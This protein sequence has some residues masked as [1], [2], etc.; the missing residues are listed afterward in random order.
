MISSIAQASPRRMIA[1][2]VLFVIFFIWLT[3]SF[4]STL[5]PRITTPK[6]GGLQRIA[7]VSMLYG[8]PNAMYERAIKSHER[9]SQ[10]W[11]LGM[12][13]LRQDISVG[14]WNKPAYLLSLVINELAKHPEDRVEWLM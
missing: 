1:G 3:S 9:H 12:H 2:V 4:R 11:G 7:K 13:V 10:K 8:K 6:F 14:F 5:R